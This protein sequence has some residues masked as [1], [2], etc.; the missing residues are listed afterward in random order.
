MDLD[1]IKSKLSF[2]G[3]E[4]SDEIMEISQVM[5]IPKSTI[6]LDS[7]KYVKVLPIVISGLVKVFTKHE[8]KELLLYYLE[9]NETCIMSY[10]ACIKNHPSK[11]LARTEEDTILLALPSDKI[12]YLENKYPRFNNLF[13]NQY[14]KRYSDLLDTINHLIFNKLD[15]RVFDFLKKKSKLLKINPIK[16][17][18]KQIASELGTAREV[19]SRI[20]KKLEQEKKIEINSSGILLL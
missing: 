4:L 19:V 11:V 5:E 2:L 12:S 17:T 15:V 18:H 20:M 14:D 9:E 8:E 13:Q 6:I 16:I 10:L 3:K 7:G 1:A